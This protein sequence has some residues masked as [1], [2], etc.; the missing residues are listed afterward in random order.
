MEKPEVQAKV[1]EM[2]SQNTQLRNRL[3][4]A[5]NRVLGKRQAIAYKKMLGEPFD[6]SKIRGGLG[7]GP[8]NGPGN[9]RP[10]DRSRAAGKAQASSPAKSADAAATAKSG[11]AKNSAKGKRKSLR[12]LRGLE[13]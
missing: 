1:E 10:P 4:A 12:E 9:G 3:A 2:R 11:A 6:V 7:K 5:V 8:W 13:D